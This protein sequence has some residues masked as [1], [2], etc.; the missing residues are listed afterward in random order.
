MKYVVL[1]G[2]GMADYPLKELEDRTPL[3]I[4]RT[5]NMDKIAREGCGGF[6]RTVPKGM[7]P[8]SDVAN[9]SILGYDPQECYTGRGPLEA[10]ALGIKIGKGQVAFRCNFVTVSEGIMADYSGGHIT[11][12]EAKVLIKLLN[13]KLGSEQVTF[14]PGVSYR[15][16]AVIDESA[17]SGWGALSCIPPHDITGKPASANLPEGKGSKFLV[18]L[19]NRSREILAE[20]DV[21]KIKLDLGENP[22]N[23]IWLWGQGKTPAFS[24]FQER[25]GASGSMISAVALL[26]GIG[27]AIGMEVITVPGATGYYDT[28]YKGKAQYCLDALR[29][30]RDFVLVHVEAPDE[31]GHNGD[32]V[33]KVMAIEHFDDYVVGTVL[34]GLLDYPE[35]R[36]LVMPDHFTPLALKT[37]ISDPVPFAMCGTGI[38]ADRMSRLT[39]EEARKGKYGLVNGHEV[40]GMLIES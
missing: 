6:A 35:Y 25:F 28:N 2:D 5:P 13:E 39:E 8:G 29:R 27:Q 4:A 22:A 24:S 21:N 40:L 36:V 33:Q 3:E 11:T 16:I 37:H 17:L 18:N 12:E 14:Y 9:L 20:A 19:M 7:E 23:M 30:G 32:R 10:L 34:D 1:V 26:K 38:K 31:A 15:N